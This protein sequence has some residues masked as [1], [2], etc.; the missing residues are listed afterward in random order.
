M[1]LLQTVLDFFIHLDSHIGEIIASYGVWTYLILFLIIFA[2]TGLVVT[3]FLPGDSLIFVVG[4]FAASG[5]L[6]VWILFFLLLAAAVIGDTVNYEVGRFLGPKVFSKEMRFLNHENLMKTQRFYEK[7]GGKTIIIARFL[8]IIRTFAPF[9]AG[10]GTM[11]YLR[12]LAY[13]FVGALLWVTVALCAGYFFGNL[14][15]VKDNF[16][17][18]IFAIIGISAVPAV[19]AYIKNWLQ[20]RNQRKVST[21]NESN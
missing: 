19:Y 17:L 11:K 5:A 3:P 1:E 2:E 18:V 14:P 10:V 7:H 15:F 21:N 16:T 13:N 8:P 6:D 20:G 9:V 12:F 4:T